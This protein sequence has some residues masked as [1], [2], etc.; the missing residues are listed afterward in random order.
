MPAYG[1]TIQLNGHVSADEDW[2]GYDGRILGTENECF[3]AGQCGLPFGADPNNL[4]EHA[5][6]VA[7]A[8]FKALQ[9]RMNWIYASSG[10]GLDRFQDHWAWVRASL[11]R[12]RGNAFDAWAVLRESRD[13]Y[14]TRSFAPSN[15]MVDWTRRPWIRNMERWLV[16]RDVCGDGVAMA[17]EPREGS[18]FFADDLSFDGLRTDVAR[19]QDSLYFDVDEGFLRGDQRNIEIHVA[20]YRDAHTQWVLEYQRGDC[21]AQSSLVLGTNNDLPGLKTAVFTLPEVHFS[22]GFDGSTDFVAQSQ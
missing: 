8:N 4:Q 13:R 2:V 19:A 20:F 11:G 3:L 9:M 10:S 15:E 12:Q 17:G 14:F 7:L 21:V 5:R 1:L 6:V 22:D 16:Q 18:L